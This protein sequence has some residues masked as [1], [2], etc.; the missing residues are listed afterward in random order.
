M[1]FNCRGLLNEAADLAAL[2]RLHTVSHTGLPSWWLQRHRHNVAVL[3]LLFLW[4]SIFDCNSY[5]G[6]VTILCQPSF[7]PMSHFCAQVR[8]LFCKNWWWKKFDTIWWNPSTILFYS[9]NNCKRIG[10]EIWKL[11]AYKDSDCTFGARVRR[12]KK[13]APGAAAF[14]NCWRLKG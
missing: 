2:R 9:T 11:R 1:G 10:S 3:T 8:G 5:F 13:A 7:P 4:L 12:E 14:Q 6:Q